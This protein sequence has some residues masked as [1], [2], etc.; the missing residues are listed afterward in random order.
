MLHGGDG[1]EGTDAL[2]MVM[3]P[4]PTL[5]P[6]MLIQMM[7]FSLPRHLSLLLLLLLAPRLIIIIMKTMIIM[8]MLLMILQIMV[9]VMRMV[10]VLVQLV[11]VSHILMLVMLIILMQWYISRSSPKS[12]A[13]VPTD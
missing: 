11:I 3:V 6:S 7:S 8:L 4:G 2:V 10:V 13:L 5:H 12:H 9:M 1:D